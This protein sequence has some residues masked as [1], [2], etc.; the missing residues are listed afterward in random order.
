MKV[1]ATTAAYDGAISTWLAAQA[2][3]QTAPAT[4]EFVPPATLE[5]H[6]EKAQDLR[7]GENPHQA[8]AV[9]RFADGFSELGSLRR[10]ARGRRAAPGKAALL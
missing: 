9:Y 8:A 2:E 7:Y 3:A 10:P 4:G 1:Y 5:L 6:L